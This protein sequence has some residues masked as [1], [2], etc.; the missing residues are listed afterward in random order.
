MG[1]LK[2]AAGAWDPATMVQDWVA[3]RP[4]LVC[5]VAYDHVEASGRWRHPGRFRRWRA[6]RDPRSCTLEQLAPGPSR[7]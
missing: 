7:S 5:E 3:V 6:D 1:P 4:E 2:G